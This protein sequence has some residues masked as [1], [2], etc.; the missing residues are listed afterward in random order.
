MPMNRKQLLALGAQRR[1][2]PEATPVPI[3]GWNTR[4]ALTA[5]APTDAIVLDNFY[6][7]EN[8]CTLRQGYVQFATGLGTGVVPTLAALQAGSIAKFL[9]GANGAIYDITAGGAVGAAL[10]SGFASNWWQTILFNKHLFWFNGTDAP[11]IYDGSTVGA[12]SFTAA[13][14]G[15]SITLSNLK[16]G[17]AHMNRLFLFENANT[18]F[19]Y[20]PLL[21]ISGTVTFFD[22]SMLSELGGNVATISSL[23]YDGGSGVIDFLAITMSTGEL[24][25]YQ[26]TDPSSSTTWS[27]VGRYRL[28]PPVNP[29]S[30]VR[31]GGETYMTT[32][33]DH[34]GMM[35]G[36]VALRTGILPPRTKACNA[37]KA[38][39]AANPNANGW[40]ALYYTGG[41]RVI[42][43]IPNTD[44]SFSQ[45]VYNVTNDAW[46]RFVGMPAVTWGMF[47]N[48][49]YFGGSTGGIVYQADTGYLDNGVAAITG[50]GQQAWNTFGSSERKQ[51]HAVRPLLQATGGID[52]TFSVAFD[53]QPIEV[54]IESMTPAQGT[55]WDT[56][57][58]DVSPWSA[59]FTI[60]PRWRAGG[61]S[62]VAASWTLELSATTGVTWLRTDAWADVGHGL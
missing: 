61:G 19:W 59:E 55:P 56:S 27:L 38:A 53:Y 42:F 12:A 28:S 50:T 20:G 34:I 6:P 40:Q 17:I 25:L 37:V 4:D 7:D 24:F 57:P 49:L 60:D 22:L 16:G 23:S 31:Y 33:D 62:G 9:A 13:S 32:F 18:G 41:R 3:T 35:Q 52:Y 5:M 45:H 30:I 39:V 48:R 29:R 14:G 44:G 54:S 26:G 58:W 2:Q 43:N 1:A 10:A 11:Q 51:L 15:P 36:M 21:G 46:T 47:G 8:G